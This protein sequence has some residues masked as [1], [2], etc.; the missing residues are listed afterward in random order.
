MFHSTL[1][2]P[3][4]YLLL[5]FCFT[6]LLLSSFSI[7]FIGLSV[8]SLLSSLPLLSPLLYP[9]S[10]SASPLLCM[11]IVSISLL[12]CLMHL[13]SVFVN[14]S[15]MYLNLVQLFQVFLASLSL[16]SFMHLY[17][18]FLLVYVYIRILFSFIFLSV[19]NSCLLHFKHIL[20]VSL[21]LLSL[22]LS[23]LFRGSLSLSSISCISIPFLSYVFLYLS[24]SLCHQF[25]AFC[26]HES[27]SLSPLFQISLSL[28]FN[29]SLSFFSRYLSSL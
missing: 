4:R 22:S 19:S 26:F 25:S 29:V 9:V 18:S 2:P 1:S 3:L 20:H 14:A 16:I 12:P 7:S 13:P 6:F 21:S 8:L 24:F 11:N 28:S 15:S 27:L 10:L 5:S 17:F 23:P